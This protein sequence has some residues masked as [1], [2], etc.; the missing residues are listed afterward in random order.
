MTEAE[1]LACDDPGRMLE[2]VHGRSSDRRRRLFGFAVCRRYLC[3]PHFSDGSEWAVI[4]PMERFADGALAES[5]RERLHGL[6]ADLDDLDDRRYRREAL[7]ALTAL[8]VRAAT[9]W[10]ALQ[11]CLNC[12]G[13]NE[14][15]FADA[16]ASH[17]RDIFG[18]PFHPITFSP[19]WRTETVLTLAR[20]M[21][22]ARDFSAMPILADAL[23]DAGC[24]DETILM[25]C[26]GGGP[27]TRGC[28]TI[29]A[30]L[31]RM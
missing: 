6:A 25:H 11:S 8:T 23:G 21:Y 20:T 14:V 5:E 24:E 22:E 17:V 2:F 29:D 30:I 1:W 10:W 13:Y 9:V 4:G 26:R 7:L 31:G 18:N 28:A 15:E 27:H 19:D 3:D 16:V 12:R